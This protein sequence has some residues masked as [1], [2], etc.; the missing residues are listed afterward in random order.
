MTWDVYSIEKPVDPKEENVSEATMLLP[1]NPDDTHCRRQLLLII[2]YGFSENN[3][4][5]QFCN[6]D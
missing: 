5:I 4:S 2:V 3:D 6:T 1:L